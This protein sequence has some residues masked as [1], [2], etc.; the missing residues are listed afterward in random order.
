MPEE[1]F[2]FDSQGK[3]VTEAQAAYFIKM[4]TDA[5]GKL[6]KEQIGFPERSQESVLADSISI[7][8]RGNDG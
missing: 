5:S 7:L 3:S 2:Y 8:L 6:I 4:I 1:I